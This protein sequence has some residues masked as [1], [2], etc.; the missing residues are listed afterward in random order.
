MG[1]GDIEV[2]SDFLQKRL[3]PIES[4]VDFLGAAEFDWVTGEYE[5]MP[6]LVPEDNNDECED[7]DGPAKKKQKRLVKSSPPGQHSHGCKKSQPQTREFIIDMYTIVVRRGLLIH[8]Q[9]NKACF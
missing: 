4:L 2:A 6:D 3:F 7:A 1:G 8:W 5:S 9:F